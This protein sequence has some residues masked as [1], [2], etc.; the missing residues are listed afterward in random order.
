M[1][2]LYACCLEQAPDR[3]PAALWA[4]VGWAALARCAACARRLGAWT[5]PVCWRCA[6]QRERGRGLGTVRAE[7]LAL[8][9]AWRQPL[10]LRAFD[11][12]LPFLCYKHSDAWMQCQEPELLQRVA[13]LLG[14]AHCSASIAV[15]RLGPASWAYLRVARLAV[16]VRVLRSTQPDKTL[17]L[18][19]V[20]WQ[21]QM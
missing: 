4:R 15:A 8:L 19:A 17:H 16:V 7:H 3:L 14:Y 1:Q 21:A 9:V 13:R 12:Q 18:R 2:A 6:W 20:S 5:L 10:P 11:L